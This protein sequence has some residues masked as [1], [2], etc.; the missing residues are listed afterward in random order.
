TLVRA[1]CDG[2]A[3]GGGP[4]PIRE[5]SPRRD[6]ML[7]VQAFRTL[8][9]QAP[10]QEQ[11]EKEAPAPDKAAGDPFGQAAGQDQPLEVQPPP[12]RDE[13]RIG[14]VLEPALWLVGA[15][16]LAALILK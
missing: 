11:K 4:R 7:P 14:R 16:L 5:Y 2:P 3:R 9:P 8:L 12:P 10:G 6:W 13:P 15:L 1:G